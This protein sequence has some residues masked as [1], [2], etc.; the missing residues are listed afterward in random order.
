[1]TD[2][3]TEPAVEPDTEPPVYPDEPLLDPADD[4]T[5]LDERERE[6]EL[7]PADEQQ[8]TQALLQS[9]EK[10]AGRH[11]KAIAKALGV[12]LED[13]HDCP[14]CDGIGFTP[15]P[16]DAPPPLVQDPYTETC[17]RCRG[18]GKTLS[19]ASPLALYEIPCNDCS[20]SG[21]RTKPEQP[22]AGATLSNG[23][24]PPPAYAP[25]A[26][27]SPQDQSAVAALR[28]QGYTILE[29]ITVPPP[30]PA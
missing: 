6:P 20:G 12:E 9:L 11:A 25:P 30:V 1:M 5:D 14:T 24:P 16:I 17:S 29:P 18:N 23:A 21:Y 7:E 8:S 19:G 27:A 10:E 3:T 28:A 22:D 2:D 4:G 13:L 15:E 26:I